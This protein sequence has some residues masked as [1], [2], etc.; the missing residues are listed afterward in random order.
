MENQPYEDY[1]LALLQAE[2]SQRE[3]SRQ[4][5]LVRQ[6]RFPVL[7]E[8]A[9]FDFTALPSL[10]KQRVLELAQ[11]QYLSG[12]ENLVLVGNPGLGKT[13]VA[14]SLALA[15]CRQ[16]K[17]VRFYNVAGLVNELLLAQTEQRLNRFLLQ[18]SHYQLV[19]LDEFGLSLSAHKAGSCYFKWSVIYTRK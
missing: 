14:S 11:G 3:I 10:S 6:A 8:L 4:Q 16:G 9:D 1:L 12:A 13:H 7:K 5:S 15:A 19:V 2:L 17:R 18:L